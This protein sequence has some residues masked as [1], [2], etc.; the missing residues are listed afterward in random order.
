MIRLADLRRAR[1]V[2]ALAA[3][4]LLLAGC[5]PNRETMRQ[6]LHEDN[7]RVQTA[8]IAQVVRA[9]DRTF[10]PEL[11]PLLESEDEGVRFCAAAALHKLTGQ[12]FGFHFAT[13]AEERGQI[14]GRW[15]AWWEAEGEADTPQASP[16][17]TPDEPDADPAKARGT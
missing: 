10:V 7:P 13:T 3:A 6:R 4:G 11:I 5:V 16:G 17:K 1:T 2:A 12:D 15:R 8:T 14:I 9:G